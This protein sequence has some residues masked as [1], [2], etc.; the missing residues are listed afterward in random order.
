MTKTKNRLKFL[1]ILV[2][3]VFLAVSLLSI[4]IRS[5]TISELQTRTIDVNEIGTLSYEEKAEKI[6]NQFDNIQTTVANNITTFSGDININQIDLL[7]TEYEGCDLTSNYE[8]IIDQENNTMK[9]IKTN[10][11]DGE[12][13]SIEEEFLL[14]QLDENQEP[15]LVY[16]NGDTYNVLEVLDE[17]NMEQCIFPLFAFLGISIYQAIAV[18]VAAATVITIAYVYQDEITNALNQLTSG[19]KDGVVSFWEKIKLAFGAIT[20]VALTGVIE[21]TQTLAKEIYNAAINRKDQYLLCG[22][23]TGSGF[24]PVQY[25]F[26]NYENAR[27]WIKKGGSVWSPYSSTAIKCVEGAGFVPGVIKKNVSY[28]YEAERHGPTVTVNNQSFTFGFFHYHALKKNN[29][30]KINGAHSFFGLPFEG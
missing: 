25:K 19:I 15:C 3:L 9:I 2:A 6:K 12:I 7:S 18:T 24:I 28:K 4:A 16:E 13:V 8:A 10:I 14:T 27:N 29:L 21:L 20:A 30:S 5:T 17:D 26:T 22:T 23:I 11:V 1:S